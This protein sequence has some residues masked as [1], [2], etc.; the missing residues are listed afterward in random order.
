M[1]LGG[2]N[3]VEVEA[4][5]VT[6][7]LVDVT[8]VHLVARVGVTLNHVA[9]DVETVGS[10]DLLGL[11]LLGEHDTGVDSLADPG[12]IL[13][14]LLWP[15]INESVSSDILKYYTECSEMLKVVNSREFGGTCS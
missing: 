4:K 2:C 9:E 7:E 3:G 5:N 11:A 10:V 8:V 13:L 6:T 12:L 14:A 1:Q 15:K